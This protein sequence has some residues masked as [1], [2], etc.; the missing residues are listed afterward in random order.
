M[1]VVNVIYRKSLRAAEVV[2]QRVVGLPVVRVPGLGNRELELVERNV[3]RLGDH[4][5]IVV[6]AEAREDIFIVVPGNRPCIGAQDGIGEPI[7]TLLD[8]HRQAVDVDYASAN[9]AFANSSV[10]SRAVSIACFSSCFH[11]CATSLASGSSGF[12]APSNA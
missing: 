11:C 2:V 1:K 6:G 10:H 4:D 12:G 5:I 3:V 7:A 8:H 9:S